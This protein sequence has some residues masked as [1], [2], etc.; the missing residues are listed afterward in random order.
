MFGAIALATASTLGCGTGGAGARAADAPAQAVGVVAGPAPTVAAASTVT[1]AGARC[2]GGSCRCRE[3]GR[4]DVETQP[5]GPGSKRFEIRIAAAGGTAAL[6]LSDLGTVATGPAPVISGDVEATVKTTCAYV[7]VPSGSSHQA[8][9]VALESAKGQGVAPQLSI[10]EYGPQGPFWYDI[11]AVSCSGSSGRCDRDGADAWSKE[12]RGRQRGRV[13]PCGSAVVTKLAWESS[14][15]QAERDGGLF[16]DFS[17]G[18]TMEVKK[19][20]TQFAPGSSEC[21]PK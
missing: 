8:R 18:F 17:V 16:R 13:D 3:P 5:P 4:D 15:G 14:G 21:V 10:A 9:F 6:D 2:S 19:F 12:A 1:L 7:D 11:V 20:A